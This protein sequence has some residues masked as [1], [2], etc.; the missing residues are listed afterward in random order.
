MLFR[1]YCLILFFSFTINPKITDKYD[2]EYLGEYYEYDLT[3]SKKELAFFAASKIIKSPLNLVYTIGSK[4][5]RRLK[6]MGSKIKDVFVRFDPA[7][8]HD[9]RVDSAIFGWQEM[10]EQESSKHPNSRKKKNFLLHYPRRALSLLKDAFVLV[11][12]EIP[13]ALLHGIE[14]AISGG[15]KGLNR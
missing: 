1:F 9:Y 8:K 13:F 15:I 14:G 3:R 11:G 10:I 12:I 4:T 2:A 6:R 7:Y 5:H